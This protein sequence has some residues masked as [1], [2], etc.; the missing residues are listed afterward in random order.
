MLQLPDYWLYMTHSRKVIVIGAGVAGMAA[1]IRLAVKGYEV[2]VM[3][4]NGEP[5]GKLHQFHCG[6]FTFDAGPSLFTEPS[7]IEAL[8]TLAGEPIAEYLS[9]SA[10]P[11]ACRYFYEDGT[12][13]NAYTNPQLFA[14][15]LEQKT[16]EPAGDTLAYLA[17]AGHL[18]N[19]IG[20]VFLNHSLHRKATW[21]KAPLARAFRRVQPGLLLK[22]MHQVN[23]HYFSDER[24]VQLF[25]RFATYNGSNPYQAPG[26]LSMI[27]HLEHN[28]G[29]YY[30]KGGMVSISQ[31][32]HRLAV[33]KGVQFRFH[34]TVQRIIHYN[35]KAAGVVADNGNH[36]ADVVISNMDVYFT[37]RHL[38]NDGSAAARVLRQERSSSALIFYW[39]MGKTFPQL[40]L[41]N[42]FFS[43]NYRE[44]FAAIFKRKQ[45]S[46]DPTVYVN[47]TAKCE[48]GIHAPEGKENWFVMV[49]APA[50]SGQDW[51]T[52]KKECRANI[53]AKLSRGLQTDIAPLIETEQTLDPRGIEQH[54]GS[55]MGSLYGTSSNSAMAAFMRHPNFQKQIKGLY[56]VG[57]SVHPGGGIPLCLRS[58]AIVVNQLIGKA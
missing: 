52:L 54:T 40:Q 39:G 31:A 7:N 2:T 41:H 15:E 22:S 49:N 32:L 46:A 51:D 3:E 48:P 42:I 16:G 28:E 56:F 27:P 44:E 26:M 10:L 25:N 50:N 43:S 1:A 18:Y 4:K 29:I 21:L 33:K 55:Y 36:A 45:L 5:G 6:S 20:Q 9:Y 37:Y 19:D 35:G 47:I 13:L 23:S 30:P 38:L 34:T 24:V 11:L 58:A 14:E 8:F 12:V 57:G 53:L 17:Q